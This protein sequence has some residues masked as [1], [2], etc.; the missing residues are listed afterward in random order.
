ML[1]LLSIMPVIA[2]KKDQHGTLSSL[3]LPRLW[4]WSR[5]NSVKHLPPRA[6]LGEGVNTKRH[7]RERRVCVPSLMVL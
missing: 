3:H 5:P 1:M 7:H 6:G 4:G 2:R